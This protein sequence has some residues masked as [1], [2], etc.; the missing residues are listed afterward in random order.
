MAWIEQ[1]GQEDA[2]GELK[3]VYEELVRKRGKLSNIMQV[4]SL[5]PGAMQKH[6]DLYVHLMFGRSGLSRADREAIAVVVSA[7]NDCAYC[8]S[9]HAE[10]LAHYEKND[11]ITELMKGLRFLEMSDRTGRILTYAAKLTQKPASVTEKDIEGLRDAGLS[12]EEILDVNLLTSYFNFVNR[13]ALGLG[14]GFS[15][16]ET[17]GYKL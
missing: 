1:I 6:L 16:E 8:V 15:A 12:D 3:A 7:T 13:I 17:E 11:A 5:N 10:A 2:S 4:Q 14:V 9:H